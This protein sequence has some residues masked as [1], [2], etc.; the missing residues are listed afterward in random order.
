MRRAFEQTEEKLRELSQ[1]K[2]NSQNA[3]AIGKPNELATAKLI[4][5]SKKYRDRTAEVEALKTKCKNFEATLIIK[6][7]ELEHQRAELQRIVKSEARKNSGDSK[8]L[9]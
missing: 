2:L 5:L 3:I 1:E 6:E 7:N 9:Y 8:N 4:E